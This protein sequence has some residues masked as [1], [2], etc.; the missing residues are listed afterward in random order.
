MILKCKMCGD[1]IKLSVDKAYGTC[2]SCGST[3]TLP[4]IDDEQ[5]IN[6][7]NRASYDS[8]LQ[9]VDY[10]AAIE[11]ST[12]TV[13]QN[14]YEK[15]AKYISAIQKDII[16]ISQ[17]EKPYDVFICYKETDEN[18]NRTQDSALAQD[19]YFQLIQEGYKVFFSRITLEDKL[20]QAYEPYIFAALS[21]AK[22]MLVIGTK[23]ENYNAVW[24][25]N[26]WSRY[27]NLLKKDKSRLLIPCYRD[28][29]A[30]GIPEELS[31]LQS[32]DMSKIGFMQDLIRGIKKVLVKDVS[33]TT[34]TDELINE[35]SRGVVGGN[36]SAL[37]KRGL[38]AL[39][40][41]EWKYA[42]NFFEEVLNS[43]AECAEAYLGKLCV[44][45]QCESEI[46]LKNMANTFDQN[47][48]YKKILRFDPEGLGQ[49]MIDYT[50]Y[51]KARNE[52]T[53]KLEIYNSALAEKKKENYIETIK[54]LS[55]IKGYKEVEY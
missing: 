47:P 18:G 29:D 6:L 55:T 41:A 38:M 7:Y 11:Y 17:K 13:V 34:V 32:Q 4:K 35:V 28:I 33:I 16:S 49:K 1:D 50:A 15:E 44:D 8:I 27:L 25:K 39:E 21:S 20:G 23:T 43:D 2:E 42:D 36:A 54:I 26:E 51:I 10:L 24:V 45:L 5:K 40:D 12:D 37:L 14:L 48:N 53:R 22:V 19:V 46:L 3:M 9:D 52:E 31:M 30:C